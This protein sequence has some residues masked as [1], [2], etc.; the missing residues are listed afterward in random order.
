M[1]HVARRHRPEIVLFGREQRF[2]TPLA[3]EVGSDIVVR[4]T[5]GAEIEVS[6]LFIDRSFEGSPVREEKLVVSNRV[7]DVIQAMTKLGAKYPHVV[8]LLAA[9]KR[10]G[11][12]ASR[13]EFGALPKGNRTHVDRSHGDSQ[14]RIQRN[15]PAAFAGDG[16]ERD[17]AGSR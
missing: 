12:L 4:S 8:R 13:L 1:V 6:K 9:A 14:S 15:V 16:L 5:G 3:L 11:V 7:L 2:H 10:Q 17:A